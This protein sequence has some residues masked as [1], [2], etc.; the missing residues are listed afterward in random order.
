MKKS[1][2]V[3]MPRMTFEALKGL[4][5]SDEGVDLTNIINDLNN[6]NELTAIN[7]ALVFKGLKPELSAK[8]IYDVSWDNKT[9]YR[10]ELKN[11]SLILGNVLCIKSKI[12]FNENAQQWDENFSIMD[13]NAVLPF[14]EWERNAENKLSELKQKVFDKPQK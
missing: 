9:I 3:E 4:L 6:G 7:V 5:F 13:E 14:E 12:K 1:S 2:F 10:Y 11:F 8:V